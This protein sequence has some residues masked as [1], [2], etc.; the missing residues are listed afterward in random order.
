MKQKESP[1]QELLELK[2]DFISL[3]ASPANGKPLVLKSVAKHKLF[4]IKADESNPDMK[5]AYGIVYSPD[6]PDLQNDT[7]SEATIK[8]A[9][10][11]FM[12]NGRTKNVD[13]NH[14]FEPEQAFVAESWLIRDGDPMFADA[15][16]GSWAVGIQINNDALWESLK[17][18]ELTGIS[19]AGTAATD[20]VEPTDDNCPP[21]TET[22]KADK[23]E[24]AEL[25]AAV[26]AINE[27]LS[28][29]P[30]QPIAKTKGND[31]T[32]TTEQETPIVTIG[33]L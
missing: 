23:S 32:V 1:P 11:D 6:E 30:Q 4:A 25:L 24:L 26:K 21:P 18:G 29:Q 9:A 20:D 17:K 14:S 10:D 2:V 15:K 19:L 3:V 12:L 16:K 31:F 5:R 28:Q 7:A 27:K 22:A 8:K 13:K 33:F